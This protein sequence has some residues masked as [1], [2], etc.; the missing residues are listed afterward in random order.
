MCGMY[1]KL[2][3]I[4]ISIFCLF[5]IFTSLVHAAPDDQL[6]PGEI[7]IRA[8]VVRV[9]HAGVST[10]SGLSIYNERMQVQLLEGKEKGKLVIVDRSGDPKLTANTITQ[11]ET[12][13]IDSKPDP[14]GHRYY[15]VYEPYRLPLFYF[16]IAVFMLFIIAVAGKR[17]LGALIGLG[18]SIGIIGMYIIPQILAGTDPLRVSI[19]GSCV[20]LLLTT[21]IAHGVS[22]KTT[23]AVIGTGV[24]LLFA[25]FLAVISVS[26]LHLFGLGSEDIYA[27]QVG[28]VHPINPQGLLLGGILIGTLG[29]LNDI[30]TTQA[31]TIF[32][33]MKE[34]PNKKF[35]ELFSMG[36]SI[37]REHIASLIN[38]LVLAY[39]G[40]S[41]AVFIFFE[42]NPAQL[43]WWVILN[44][45]STM[46]E[47]MKSI[48]GSSALILAVPITTFLASWVAMRGTSFY[49]FFGELGVKLG[50]LHTK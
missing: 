19:L 26:W 32:T 44:N 50:L 40:S 31:L 22:L 45:E 7:Y 48:I 47:I 38:T 20:I 6:D 11:G 41:L 13:I 25:G 35:K 21:Y 24:S 33:F 12:V 14:S 4:F 43:P 16:F 30:T 34:H 42:L 1:K 37:G 29:A 28:A 17:G 2:F 18:V 15:T 8:T 3:I 5:T 27:L 49:E 9:L 39:A 23:V 46:E 36:M 10:S